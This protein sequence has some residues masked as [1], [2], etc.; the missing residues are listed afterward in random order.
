VEFEITARPLPGLTINL[1]PAWLNAVLDEA[2]LP[3]FQGVS[4]LDG[5]Q[6]A[7]APHVTF[8]AVIDYK[9]ALG[10]GDAVDLRWNSNYRSHEWFDSTN[11][12]YIQQNAYWL[13]NLTIEFQSRK[14]WE[15]GVFVRNLTGTKYALTSSDLTSPFGVLTPVIGPPC[16]YGVELSTHF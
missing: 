15:V 14:G 3:L 7:N 13:H 1:Q 10:G 2:G 4:S 8:S 9:Y 12:P 5:K 11:D 16:T 6:L